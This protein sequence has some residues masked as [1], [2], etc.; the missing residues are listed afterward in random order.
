ME[1]K[2][3]LIVGGGFAGF[4]A[5]S[6]FAAHSRVWDSDFSLILADPKKHFEF[7]PMLPDVVRGRVRP[8][9][10]RQSLEEACHSRG[11]VFLNK[12]VADVDVDGKTVKVGGKTLG[13]EYIIIASGSESDFYGNSELKR[14]CFTMCS[15]EDAVSLR[16]ELLA[17]ISSKREI[18]VLVVGGG[19]TGVETACAVSLLLENAARRGRVM[20]AEKSSAL[21]SVSPQWIRDFSR[22]HLEGRGIEVLTD[23]SLEKIDKGQA[24]LGSGRTI[25]DVICVWAAGVRNPEFLDDVPAQTF[26][27]RLKVGSSMALYGQTGEKGIYVAGDAAGFYPGNSEIPLRQAV[28]F[29]I[30]QGRV[31]S[32]NIMRDIRGKAPLKCRVK[33]LGYVI[34]L[35]GGKAPGIVLGV[36]TPPRIGFFLHY[37]MCFYRATLSGKMK[38]IRDILIKQREEG[39]DEK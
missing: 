14:S 32:A 6:N 28:M 24:L 35:T 31:A 9:T 12:S 22:S 1:K 18:N 16:R 36:K 3:I 21:L 5:M 29:A 34:P 4:T 38:M 37:F 20:L 11:C 30:A 7:L 33:D 17:R 26:R 10:L 2:N 27:T 23:E 19:Y 8:E 39:D 15:V 25:E 13:Y